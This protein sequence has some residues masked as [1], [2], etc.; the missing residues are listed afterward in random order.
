MYNNISRASNNTS[1]SYTSNNRSSSQP[2]ANSN[3]NSSNPDQYNHFDLRIF[4]M[5]SLMYNDNNRQIENLMNE[6]HIIR[7]TMTQMISTNIGS[8]FR[9]STNRRRAAPSNYNSY[10]PILRYTLPTTSTS[11][12]EQNVN[13]FASFFDPIQVFPS[14]VQYELATRVLQYSDIE[15]PLNTSCPISLETFVP[16]Q[17]VTV[18]RHCNHIF[19]TS[20]IQNWFLSNCRCPV[21]R[22]DIRDF[23]V[24]GSNNEVFRTESSNEISQPTLSS[25]PNSNSNSSHLPHT[26][27]TSELA[28]QITNLLLNQMESGSNNSTSSDAS[29]NTNLPNAATFFFRYEN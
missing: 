20:N 6:N 21:C 2:S 26:I 7:E 1:S 29:N 11:N 5:L 24:D 12:D 10:Q 27:S 15:T 3:R 8:N 9:R 14:Q 13:T 19:T 25:T 23:Q 16:E 28:D 4:E 18:I 17:N 22:Y